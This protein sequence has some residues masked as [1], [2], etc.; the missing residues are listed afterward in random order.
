MVVEVT[1]KEMEAFVD[2]PEELDYMS[3]ASKE[4][5]MYQKYEDR[6]NQNEEYIQSNDYMPSSEINL[7]I[8]NLPY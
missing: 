3:R 1:D 6:Y 5:D 2:I 7:E 8:G 4:E